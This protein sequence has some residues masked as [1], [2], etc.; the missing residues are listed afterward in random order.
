MPVVDD[1][2]ALA[3]RDWPPPSERHH[4]RRAKETVE[5]VVIK[6]HAQTVSDQP[7]GNRVKHLA[8]D[9]GAG[10]RDVD[11]DLLVVGGPVARQV[12]QRQPL[13]ID[14]LGV[15]SVA[16]TDNLVDEAP[17]RREI[18]EVARGAQQQRVGKRPLEMAV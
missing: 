17:P 8:Q 16:A 15:A 7:R 1:V 2:T 13:L 3:V 10:G 9:E 11:V 12:L 4:R 18:V 5:P 6:A 14:A